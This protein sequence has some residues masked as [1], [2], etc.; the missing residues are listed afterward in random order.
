MIWGFSLGHIIANRKARNSIGN[1]ANEGQRAILTHNV[2]MNTTKFYKVLSPLSLC[3]SRP[4]LLLPTTVW[5][6]GGAG[7]SALC[8]LLV[9]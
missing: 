2:S 8:Q 6:P 5:D 4:L 7:A 1:L 3:L 9:S